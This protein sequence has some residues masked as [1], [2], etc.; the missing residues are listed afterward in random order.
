MKSNKLESII[1]EETDQGFKVVIHNSDVLSMILRDTIPEFEG[2]DLESIK[3]CLELGE[4]RT[5]VK[6][7]DPEY[8][9][10]KGK[11]TLDSRFDILLPGKKGRTPVILGIESQKEIGNSEHLYNRMLYYAGRMISNQKNRDF[12]NDNYQDM[13]DVICIWLILRPKGI[14]KNDI[15]CL[16]V[17]GSS[18]CHEDDK[19]MVFDKLKILIV[20]LGDYAGD[21]ENRV[22][23]ASTLFAPDLDQQQRFD[24]VK[25]NYNIELDES[26][27]E[28]VDRIMGF[29]DNSIQAERQEGEIEGK[30]D[31]ITKLVRSGILSADD[32]DNLDEYDQVKELVKE[33]LS[34]GQ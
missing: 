34:R 9:S 12:R 13:K 11:A 8:P 33:N 10:R 6:G 24:L 20:G 19:E 1:R 16:K 5:F 7:R 4:D 17:R 15:K 30:V 22:R 2:M 23:F 21:I 18:I 28:G 29:Y 14:L 31:T 3:D 26:V 25:E 27:L 32:I